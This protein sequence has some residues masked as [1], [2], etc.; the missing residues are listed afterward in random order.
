MAP[1]INRENVFFATDQ[2]TE[3]GSTNVAQMSDQIR[4]SC[5]F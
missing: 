1:D 3:N 2:F 5:F 4:G